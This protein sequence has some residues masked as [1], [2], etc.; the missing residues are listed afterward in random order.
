MPKISQFFA[1]PTGKRNAKNF[2]TSD[3]RRVFAVAGM[4]IMFL[5]AILGLVLWITVW[6]CNNEQFLM[7]T[8]GHDEPQHRRTIFFDFPAIKDGGRNQIQNVSLRAKLGK[9][10]CACLATT[11]LNGCQARCGTIAKRKPSD[12]DH[13]P[14]RTQVR[15]VKCGKHKLEHECTIDTDLINPINA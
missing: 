2:K 10:N 15:N 1:R 5:W 14:E 13:V 12:C 4:R 3:K 11:S 6:L 9:W 8:Y 7:P